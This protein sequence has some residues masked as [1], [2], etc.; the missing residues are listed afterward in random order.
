[1]DKVLPGRRWRVQCM[2]GDRDKKYIFNLAPR[3]FTPRNFV[4]STSPPTPGGQP[5]SG[6]QLTG[7]VQLASYYIASGRLAGQWPPTTSSA[8]ELLSRC[9]SCWRYAPYSY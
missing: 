4:N 2:A 5:R 3:T 9:S 1:M 7:G 8:P 6:I